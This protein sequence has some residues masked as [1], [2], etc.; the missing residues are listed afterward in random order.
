MATV[1]STSI[2]TVTIADAEKALSALETA[3]EAEK[4]KIVAVV[5]Q[6]IAVHQAQAQAHSAEV[7]AAQAILAKALP[8]AQ[9][10]PTATQ[11]A[12][13]VLTAPKTVQK[14]VGFV[15]AQWRWFVLGGALTILGLAHHAG[16]LR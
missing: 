2:S 14:V 1:S 7:S 12:A 6:H 10:T 8:A 13:L 3:F 15:A 16:L 5:Q 11:A 4:A 9:A